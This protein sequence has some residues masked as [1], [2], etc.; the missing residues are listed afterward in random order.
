M[1]A[2]GVSSAPDRSAHEEDRCVFVICFQEGGGGGM[3]ITIP[4]F[5]M[6]SSS[7]KIR[8]CLLKALHCTA[9]RILC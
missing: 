2:V 7:V 9:G 4:P 3:H 8:F 5:F 6:R 1:L